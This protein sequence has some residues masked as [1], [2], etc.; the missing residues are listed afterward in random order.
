L[1]SKLNPSDPYQR[2]KQFIHASSFLDQYKEW[3]IKERPLSVSDV[4]FGVLVLR[5]SSYAAEFLPSPSCTVDNIN[6]IT[7]TEIRDIC[8]ELGNSLARA[9]LT[10]DWK[11][12][13]VR[14]QHTLFASL[15]FSCN[16]RTDK[17]WEG[18]AH[19]THAAQKVGLHTDAN[20]KNMDDGGRTELEIEIR[21]R[22]LCNLYILDRYDWLPLTNSRQFLIWF[23]TSH[24]TDER[25]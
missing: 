5:I 21:R 13:L 18:I 23:P 16:A 10:L 15:K 25:P 14:V 20:N 22:T 7:L 9:T 24:P 8:S 1:R 6:G 11:G 12:S 19:A 4:E 3:W 2:I 17:F